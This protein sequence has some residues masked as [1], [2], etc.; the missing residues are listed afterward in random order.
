MYQSELAGVIVALT[1]VDILVRHHDITVG[2]ITIALDGESALKE[3][4]GDWPLSL[5]QKA[6]DYL[7]DIWFWIQIS[8]HIIH[9]RHVKGHQTDY[10]RYDQLDWWGQRNEDVDEGAKCFLAPCTIGRTQSRKTQTHVQPLL[11]LEK[12]SI[13]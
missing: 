4:R 5:D 1:I 10:V 9:F 2:A 7:Q 6:F 3:C 13:S 12:W 8:P 11:H